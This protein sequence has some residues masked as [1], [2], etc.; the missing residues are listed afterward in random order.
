MGQGTSSA[1]SGYNL[2]FKMAGY[3]GDIDRTDRN[4]DSGGYDPITWLL[5][6]EVPAPAT[7]FLLLSGFIGIFKVSKKRAENRES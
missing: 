2:N 3:Y 7:L 4:S 1:P 6:R 5:Y